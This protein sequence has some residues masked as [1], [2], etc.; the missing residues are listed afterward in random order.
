[1]K[2]ARVDRRRFIKATVGGAAGWA[3]ISTLPRKAFGLA[4]GQSEGSPVETQERTK[5]MPKTRAKIKFAVVGIN[6]DH[7]YGQV[8]AVLQGGGELVS[9]YAKEAE[10]AAVFSKRFPQAKPARSED[11]IKLRSDRVQ[12]AYKS[13][14]K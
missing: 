3:A 12:R 9:F 6:H 7:I 11:E 14:I 4:V 8:Q 2:Q 1:M 10:L 13:L 5:E